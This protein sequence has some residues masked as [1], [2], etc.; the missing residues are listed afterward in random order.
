[1]SRQG[2]VS[3]NPRP[4]PGRSVFTSDREWVHEFGKESRMKRFRVSVFVLLAACM[5]APAWAQYGL[6]GAPD[7]LPLSPAQRRRCRPGPR[8]PRWH[9]RASRP[10]RAAGRQQ[11]HASAG[12]SFAA[13]GHGRRRRGDAAD[14]G[15]A[16]Q[17]DAGATP[18]ANNAAPLGPTPAAAGGCLPCYTPS[19]LGC[20]SGVTAGGR[21]GWA[22]AGTAA[23]PAT[24]A[25]GTAR[26]WDWP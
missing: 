25:S 5:A 1:M 3:P 15:R 12:R 16:A 6:Y 20:G 2:P 18:A 17:T 7:I 10:R 13:D 23:T 9:T 26:C 4:P 22:A 11:L 24:A 19:Y 8:W 14:A 21:G